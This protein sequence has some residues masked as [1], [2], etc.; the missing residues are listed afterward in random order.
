MRN[1]LSMLSD[2]FCFCFSFNFFSFLLLCFIFA[3][4]GPHLQSPRAVLRGARYVTARR[5][6]RAPQ[7]ITI[8]VRRSSKGCN[9]NVRYK[10]GCLATTHRAA[11]RKKREYQWKK[12]CCRVISLV[13]FVFAFDSVDLLAQVITPRET[14]LHPL[15][16]AARQRLI[17][18]QFLYRFCSFITERIN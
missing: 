3:E 6:K 9:M 4:L 2:F 14:F 11:R 15:V 8:L 16:E 13:S 12:N 1:Q 7:I 10:G 17:C 18:L 5:K